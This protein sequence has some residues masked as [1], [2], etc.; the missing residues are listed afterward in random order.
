MIVHRPAGAKPAGIAAAQNAS[1]D[2]SIISPVAERLVVQLAGHDRY[3]D[4]R[5]R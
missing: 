4:R 3:D 2:Q 1:K 5:W